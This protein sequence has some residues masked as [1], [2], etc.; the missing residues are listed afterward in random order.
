MHTVILEGNDLQMFREYCR[1]GLDGSLGD[2]SRH[3]AAVQL[4]VQDDGRIV[5]GTNGYTSQ[6]M[7]RPNSPLT[8]AVPQH[9]VEGRYAPTFR[10]EGDRRNFP[11]EG[12]GNPYANVSDEDP[13]NV[14]PR[15]D[16]LER[17]ASQ[18]ARDYGLNLPPLQA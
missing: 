11:P 8:Q 14:L 10:D 5:L 9:T 16:R 1:M 2:L 17:F 12:S 4:Y 3:D 18:V 15:L 6:P 7:G 13:A